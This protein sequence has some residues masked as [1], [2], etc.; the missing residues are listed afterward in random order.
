MVENI[1]CKYSLQNKFLNTLLCADDS[2]K[3]KHRNLLKATH[4]QHILILHTKTFRRKLST[5][6]SHADFVIH[7]ELADHSTL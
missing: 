4:Q 7:A 3:P 6:C 1:L 5:V 2:Q